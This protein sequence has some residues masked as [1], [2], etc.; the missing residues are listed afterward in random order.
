MLERHPY[1]STLHAVC[2]YM[3]H[4]D[5]AKTGSVG[6]LQQQ[7]G[8]GPPQLA[9]TGAALACSA[10]FDGHW[11]AVAASPGAACPATPP[12][13]ASYFLSATQGPGL[14]LHALEGVQEGA[15]PALRAVGTWAL[16][17]AEGAT[18]SA[19]ASAWLGP[20]QAAG[21]RALASLADGR[22]WVGTLGREGSSQA[23]AALDQLACWD[24]HS[25]R[26][27]PMEVWCAAPIAHAAACS[28]VLWSGGDDGLLKGW[29]LRASPGEGSSA[30]L[31]TSRAHTA[32]V[33]CI[34]PLGPGSPLVATGSYDQVL[35][36]WDCRAMG[37]E[38]LAQLTL[39]GGVW[40]IKWQ[41]EGLL[42]AA[43]MHG[44]A[45]VVRYSSS[46]SS[47]GEALS[48]LASYQGHEAK[49]LTYGV[50][51]LQSESAEQQG[52]SQRRQH[53]LAS[54][55]FYSQQVHTWTAEW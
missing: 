5:G 15:S 34:A 43:C 4:S 54:C 47:S 2:T 12:P 38:P 22:L 13:A 41:G 44:G 35:R 11:D 49:A 31:F 33:T 55:A 26:G 36:L 17:C 50:E 40:R 52:S 21:V 25:L 24:A 8:G 18:G 48:V 7:G 46:S 9:P 29:D 23:G 51:W 1:Y 39:P 10:V 37:G 32:G 27:V 19:L 6:L 14:S 53:A 30:P 16:P 42:A 20:A 28:S 45:S 3:L